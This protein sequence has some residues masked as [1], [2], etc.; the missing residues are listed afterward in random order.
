M[1][2]K[3]KVAIVTGGSRGIGRATAI[4]LAEKGA[5]VALIYKSSTEKAQEVEEI[6]KGKGRVCKIYKCDVSNYAEVEKVVSQ[7]AND[8]GSI[9]ILVNNAGIAI[10]ENFVETR[11]ETWDKT[12]D[13]NLKGMFNMCRFIVPQML[14]HGGGKIVNVS[15][16]AGRNGG[17]LGV[18]YAASKAGAIGLTEALASEFTPKGILVNA[19][20]PGPVYTDLLSNLP[21]E[22]IRNLEKLSPVGRFAYPEEIAHAI[23]FLIENDYVSGEVV[24]INAG[25]YM[26]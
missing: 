16:L 20:A 14:K 19:V 12:I 5:K 7:I 11:E 9:N 8:L 1:E 24:N 17:T 4:M 23:V 3:G 22:A 18:P 6:I 13:I 26:N 2:I 10:K 21:E 25:R 15:S